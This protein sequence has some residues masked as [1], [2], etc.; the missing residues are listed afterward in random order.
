MPAAVESLAYAYETA[1]DVPWHR[2]GTRVPKGA[3]LED[4]YEPS[5]LA[6]RVHKHPLSLP[7]GR[8]TPYFAI[9]RDTDGS[10]LGSCTADYQVYQNEWFFELAESLQQDER[11]RYECAGSLLGGRRVFILAALGEDY[12]VGGKDPVRPYLLLTTNHDGSGAVKGGDT[13][14]RVVCANTLAVAESTLGGPASFAVRHTGALRERV[15]EAFRG[16]NLVS[17]HQAKLFERLEQLAQQTIDERIRDEVFDILVPPLDEE[18]TTRQRNSYDRDRAVLEQLWQDSP[19]VKY[20]GRENAWGL[21][22]LATEYIDHAEVRRG[23][24][25]LKYGQDA[26]EKRALFSLDG[27]GATKR[28]KVLAVLTEKVG[29]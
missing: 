15:E 25:V 16:L 22:S 4:I 18:A 8:E 23:S 11:V 12:L 19:A 1:R 29:A 7:D 10:I 6:W 20:A 3:T 26:V 24:D 21:L 27:V 13:A 2:L 14:T 5:G 9:V 17:R 28:E